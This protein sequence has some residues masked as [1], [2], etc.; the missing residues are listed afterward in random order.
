MTLHVGRGHGG[1]LRLVA[2]EAVESD[3]AL[4]DAPLGSVVL[5]EDVLGSDFSTEIQLEV[6]PG[7]WLYPMVFDELV[8]PALPPAQAAFPFETVSRLRCGPFA[9][10][11]NQHGSEKA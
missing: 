1:L 11:L 3:A 8:H 4:M 6:Q 10:S 9:R 7:S 5:E 2:G